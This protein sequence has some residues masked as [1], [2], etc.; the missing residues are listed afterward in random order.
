MCI[1]SSNKSS[2]LPKRNFFPCRMSA[3]QCCYD[4]R[5]GLIDGAPGG[6]HSDFISPLSDPHSPYLFQLLHFEVDIAPFLD[7]CK[8]GERL[9]LEYYKFRPSARPSCQ[10]NKPIPG[11]WLTCT[12]G[13]HTAKL[14][15]RVSWNLCISLVNY[16]QLVWLW[17]LLIIFIL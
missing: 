16:Q 8:A 3:R 17:Y 13:I 10:H 4:N 14:H 5:G 15:L 2:Y 12:A 7:C 11:M 9:C 6:G 1:Y